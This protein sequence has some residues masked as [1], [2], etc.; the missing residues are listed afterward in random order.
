[1]STRRATRRS[2]GGHHHV[3]IGVHG[4]FR[5]GEQLAVPNLDET[6]SRWSEAI[7]HE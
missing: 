4:R 7:R 5:R 2:P 6:R 1:M 3:H